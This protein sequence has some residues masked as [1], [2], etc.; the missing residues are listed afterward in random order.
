MFTCSTPFVFSDSFFCSPSCRRWV[1]L[2]SWWSVGW[3]PMV[4]L[5]QALMT[6]GCWI[7]VALTQELWMSSGTSL[8]IWFKSAGICWQQTS[9]W[10][11]PAKY[12][13]LAYITYI[14]ECSERWWHFSHLWLELLTKGVCRLG[15][16][17]SLMQILTDS[18]EQHLHLWCQT[19]HQWSPCHWRWWQP[20]GSA[21]TLGLGAMQHSLDC[22]GW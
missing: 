22:S 3:P 19:S 18:E 6:E 4:S 13:L 10:E 12:T 1:F 17:L 16:N 14:S 9:P 5:W 11:L 7:S 20:H 8:W 2:L 15:Q 21:V